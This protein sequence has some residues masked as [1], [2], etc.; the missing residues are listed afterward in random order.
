MDRNTIIG[1]SL[2]FLILVGYY[3]WTSPS[4]EE[5]AREQ[6]TAD[7]IARVEAQKVKKAPVA[8]AKA[9]SI[10]AAVAKAQDSLKLANVAGGFAANTGKEEI[11]YLKNK[12]L[13]LG[14]STKG[15]RI[16]S[17]VLNEHKRSDKSALE[18]INPK[19]SE[20]Y[21]ELAVPNGTL[22]T[23]AF[24]WKPVSKTD[25][26]LTMRLDNGAG[27][28]MDQV[29]K[30][31]YQNYLVDY[32]LVM[33]GMQDQVMKGNSDLKLTWRNILTN[34]EKELKWETQN[35]M[36]MYKTEGEDT[37]DLGASGDGKTE[38]VTGKFQWVAYKQQYFNSTLI[39]KDALE[40]DAKLTWAPTKV[41]NGV[42]DMKSELYL[43]YERETE[44]SYNLSFYFGP[45]HYKTLK[46]INAGTKDLDLQ[47]IVP[48]G[49]FGFVS[50]FIV[51]PVF[52]FLG[53]YIGS[54]GIIILMLTFIIKFL[55]LPLVYK[56]YISTAKMRILKPELDAIKEKHNGD[57]QKMQGE[58]MALY[59][60]AG[61]SPLSGCIPILLQMPILF[62]MFQFFPHAFELR[63]K[64]FLWSA[65]LSQYDSILNLGFHIPFYGDHVS[66]FTLLMTVSTLIYTR[67]N[68]QISGVSGQ[69]KWIGYF[70]PIIFLGVLNEYASGLTWYYFVSNI[71]TFAQQAV[72]RRTVNDDKLHAQIAEARKKPVKKSAFSS[73]L[74]T[75]MKQAQQKQQ[76][77]QK[78]NLPGKKPNNNKKK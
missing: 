11:I 47:K 66:L 63:Q 69:M 75:A 35:S 34:Q 31:N 52:D 33:H 51:I 20:F 59:R 72:I 1:F 32:K 56:S 25:S 19:L 76:A 58:N 37:K 8:A 67:L 60:K 10:P 48:L 57:L 14:I 36:L 45:N 44:K 46:N 5:R 74:E 22:R 65:D 39:S 12:S 78:K 4:P 17:A 13:T 43:N 68:N 73:R 26:T 71:I 2:I 42:K 23:D 41:A 30:L 38:S 3:W 6:R 27:S 16:A 7:S 53:K 62:A 77:A 18:L 64:A 49:W 24:T 29:Y 61:V 50:R 40:K 55:L 9:D 15:G 21:Y 28:Y 70:M 54:M